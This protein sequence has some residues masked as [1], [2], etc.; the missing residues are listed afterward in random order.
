M[1]WSTYKALYMSI[2]PCSIEKGKVG[3]PISGEKSKVLN[4][5]Q[6][7]ISRSDQTC[8]Q[9]PQIENPV[10]N[11]ALGIRD[12]VTIFTDDPSK[13]CTFVCGICK[14][15]V[16]FIRIHVKECHQ[17]SNQQYMTMY[18]ELEYKQKTFHRYMFS[19]SCLH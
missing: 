11:D 6:S 18:P 5:Y 10:T 19:F 14:A 15:A 17:L 8:N 2:G 12:E 9:E 7:E 4:L 13:S 3:I 16:K 1:K